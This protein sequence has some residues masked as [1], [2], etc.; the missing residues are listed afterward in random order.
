[1]H[2]Q[3]VRKSY[4]LLPV[5][6]TEMDFTGLFC[7]PVLL[8]DDNHEEHDS[9]IDDVIVLSPSVDSSVDITSLE[10]HSTVL[11]VS[12]FSHLQLQTTLCSLVSQSEAVVFLS[13]MT[14]C[15]RLAHLSRALYDM[16]V[17][18]VNLND[19][20]AGSVPAEQLDYRPQRADMT[21]VLSD[22]I[23]A[24]A[25]QRLILLYDDD[26]GRCLRAFA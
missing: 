4:Q 15:S 9:A 18:L 13:A 7:F 25:W 26:Y 19:K 10:Y 14:S 12:S 17:P 22:V 20:C 3:C 8:V 11:D 1:M 23:T 16:R 24:A 2:E 6:P 21:Q 5:S